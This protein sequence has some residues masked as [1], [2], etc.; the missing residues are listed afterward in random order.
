M[1]KKVRIKPG[2]N[3]A[4]R[5]GGKKIGSARVDSKGNLRVDLKP[6]RP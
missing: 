6:P 3:K 4:L 1:V 5:E 2:Q